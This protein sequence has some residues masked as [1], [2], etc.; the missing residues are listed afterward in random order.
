MCFGTS[1][2]GRRR[3]IFTAG[4][5]KDRKN[6]KCS[7]KCD[8]KKIK[9][10]FFL[11][12]LHLTIMFYFSKEVARKKGK[13]KRKRVNEKAAVGVLTLH[14]RN[15]NKNSWN[16]EARHCTWYV[17]AQTHYAAYFF[18]LFST[19]V[20]PMLDY[21]VLCKRRRKRNFHS[22]SAGVTSI[23]EMF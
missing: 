4:I 22:F 14:L 2:R 16:D 7:Y 11:F 23:S 20:V 10:L 3:D 9:P 1:R 12:P 17:H 6:H 5:R 21:Y 18:F 8:G 13:R 19:V 15:W